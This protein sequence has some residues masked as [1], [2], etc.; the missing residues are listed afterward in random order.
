[1]FERDAIHG[2]LDSAIAGQVGPSHLAKS[3]ELSKLAA[4]TTQVMREVSAPRTTSMFK[5]GNY[6]TPGE[7]I[8]VAA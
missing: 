2:V 3:A 1:M 5:R 4:P 7:P 6:L 8:S